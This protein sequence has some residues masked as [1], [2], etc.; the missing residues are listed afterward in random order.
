M[1]RQKKEQLIANLKNDISTNEAA[2]L[3]NYRGLSVAQMQGLRK[4]LK[5]GEAHLKV[6]KAR[7]LRRALFEIDNKHSLLSFCKEQIALIFVPNDISFSA[8]VLRNFSK[9]Y[10]NLAV[11]AGLF[12][13]QLLDKDAILSIALLPSRDV[14]LAQ[15]CGVIK[16]PMTRLA[17]LLNQIPLKLIWTLRAIEDKKGAKQ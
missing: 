1:N 9:K 14:L 15:V 4:N 6:V 3:I 2:F 13:D 11:V 7:L 12:E 5:G 16:S 17:Y 10:S 8:K